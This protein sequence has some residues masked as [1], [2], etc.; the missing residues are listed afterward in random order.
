MFRN[1]LVSLRK[2]NYRKKIF[3]KGKLKA[4][5]AVM[6]LALLVIG[7]ASCSGKGSSI[8][9]TWETEDGIAR[10]VFKADGTG[11][12]EEGSHGVHPIA[13]TVETFTHDGVTFYQIYHGASDGGK[14]IINPYGTIN[15]EGGDEFKFGAVFKR[16]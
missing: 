4:V 13:Y 8:V 10:Y 1:E 15:Y 12:Y 5:F 7:M 9:G 3:M 6:V 11:T 2:R 16:K 14:E